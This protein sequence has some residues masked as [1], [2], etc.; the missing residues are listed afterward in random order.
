M[1]ELPDH[2]RIIL[3]FDKVGSS[4]GVHYP[5]HI[6]LR[7]QVGTNANYIRLTL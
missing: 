5:E 2:L 3:V 7:H 4:D 6:Q 1:T